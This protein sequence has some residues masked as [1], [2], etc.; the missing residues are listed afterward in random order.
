MITETTIPS[1]TTDDQESQILS[2]KTAEKA[3]EEP[4]QAI[5]HAYLSDASSHRSHSRKK[6]VVNEW[7]REKTPTK[8][9]IST[10]ASG[11]ESEYDTD[12]SAETKRRRLRKKNE[13][14]PKR[15]SHRAKT[16]NLEPGKEEN[17]L[18]TPHGFFMKLTSLEDICSI[19]NTPYGQRLLEVTKSIEDH[20]HKE[21]MDLSTSS[22]LV[23]EE[24][25]ATSHN[26]GGSDKENISAL[27][28][29]FHEQTAESD[30]PSS[31]SKK[32]G[33]FDT[34][35]ITLKKYSHTH[36]KGRD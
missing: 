7:L 6:K 1:E 2:Q 8:R 20:A 32:R 19:V 29:S 3:H 11:T 23:L 13:P 18:L 12:K 31:P 17:V 28:N 4:A 9:K 36:R 16:S 5:E 14:K 30:V 27:E 35:N 15:A 26:V 33:L 22:H 24:N 34:T 10:S 25:L 21:N